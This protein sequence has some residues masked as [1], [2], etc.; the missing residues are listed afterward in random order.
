MPDVPCRWPH[1]ARNLR[2]S[3][4]APSRRLHQSGFQSNSLITGDIESRPHGSLG[5]VFVRFGIAEI[6]QYPVAPEV[7]EDAVIGSRNTGTGGVIGAVAALRA[8][9]LVISSDSFFFSPQQSARRAGRTLRCAHDVLRRPQALGLE[10]PPTLL[11]IRQ[12]GVDGR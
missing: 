2:R 4:R 3:H 7:G 5:I 1:R 6:G 9:G 12:L 11:T 10:V 8:G